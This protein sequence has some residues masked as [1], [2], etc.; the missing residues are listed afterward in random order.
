MLRIVLFMLLAS[1]CSAKLGYQYQQ[2]TAGLTSYDTPPYGYDTAYTPL[3]AT[4]SADQYNEHAD[5]HKHFYAFEA[6]YDSIEEAELIEQKIA[7]ISQKN[8]QVVF[9]KAPENKVVEGALHALAKQNSEDKTAIYVLNKQTDANELASKLSALQTQR[10]HKPQVHFVKYRTDAEAAQAQQQIQAQYDGAPSARPV[11]EQATSLGYYPEQQPQPDQGY[12][13]DAPSPQ[14]A[15]LPPLPSYASFPQG[16]NAAAQG[17]VDL[18]PLP[19]P[20]QDNL[21]ARTAKS[22]RIDFRV[23]E[24]N[25]PGSRMIFPTESQPRVYLPPATVSNQYLP[26]NNGIKRRRRAY[27]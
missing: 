17:L 2:N 18:P 3:P 8:L 14:S 20:Q 7:A 19:E 15:Y 12:Y 4:Q 16:Y 21:D 9:I 11:A 13:P 23:N 26:P 27:F 5:F 22:S 24:R 25:R 10:K 6:P 1:R